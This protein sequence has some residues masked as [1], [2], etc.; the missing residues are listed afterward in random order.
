MIACVR[1]AYQKELQCLVDAH[2]DVATVVLAQIIRRQEYFSGKE[3]F[4]REDYGEICVRR[5]VGGNGEAPLLNELAKFEAE[6]FFTRARGA[7]KHG[8]GEF[9]IFTSKRFGG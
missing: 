4:V 6:N 8:A 9:G 2:G 5:T 3:A 1:V 7:V